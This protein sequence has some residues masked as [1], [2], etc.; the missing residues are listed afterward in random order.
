MTIAD[1]KPHMQSTKE[2]GTA[3]DRM[4]AKRR[5]YTVLGLVLLI[6]AFI[7]SVRFADESNAGHF[8]DR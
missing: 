2:I 6:A 8:F 4:I 3:W 5:L 1:T 7:R